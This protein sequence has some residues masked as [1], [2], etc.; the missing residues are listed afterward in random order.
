MDLGGDST[1]SPLVHLIQQPIAQQPEVTILQQI[2]SPLPP[3]TRTGSIRED[4]MELMM[5]QNAQM[6]QVI[7]NS[8]AMSAVA[9]FEHSPDQVPSGLWQVEEEEGDDPAPLVFHHHYAPYPSTPP[10]MPWQPPHRPLAWPQ[11]H[12]AIR[13]VG[14]DLGRRSR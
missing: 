12:P 14:P 5:I 4:L 6:H 13:H 3:S 9:H 1:A 11:Q 2:P 10:L 7:M 8:L